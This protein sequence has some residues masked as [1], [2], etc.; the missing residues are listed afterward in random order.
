MLEISGREYLVCLK[1]MDGHDVLVCFSDLGCS[2]WYA[3]NIWARVNSMHEVLVCFNNSGMR[4]LN[5]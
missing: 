2:Y 1:D 3:S 4:Q 5:A